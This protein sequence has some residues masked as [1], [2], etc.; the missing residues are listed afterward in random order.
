MTHITKE[1]LLQAV[2]QLEE[3]LVIVSPTE[4]LTVRELILARAAELSAQDTPQQCA[5]G[6]FDGF[7]EICTKVA[8]V[9][10]RGYHLCK[11]CADRQLAAEIKADMEAEAFYD[12]QRLSAQ[13]SKPVDLVAAWTNLK[14]IMRVL[15]A[16]NEATVKDKADAYWMCKELLELTHSAALSAQDASPKAEVERLTNELAFER[17]DRAMADAAAESLRA[18]VERLNLLV[19]KLQSRAGGYADQISMVLEPERDRLRATVAEQGAALAVQARVFVAEQN[20][21][22]ERLE[23]MTSERDI[24]KNHAENREKDYMELVAKQTP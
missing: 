14:F 3:E 17:R 5:Y 23:D 11:P 16:G 18:E 20:E 4:A 21:L 2:D 22:L 6:E 8:T 12:R 15:Q 10:R 13:E 9:N 7:K 24:Y 1:G 19:A